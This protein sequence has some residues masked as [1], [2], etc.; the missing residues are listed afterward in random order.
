MITPL[1]RP[2][3]RLPVLR[4]AGVPPVGGARPQLE[5]G[6]QLH[7]GLP[8]GLHLP[9]LLQVEGQP[10]AHQDGRDQEG[11]PRPLGVQHQV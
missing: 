4:G 8:A 9:P 11:V 7:E 2:G 6:Q 3:G 10:Q 1:Q 5:E